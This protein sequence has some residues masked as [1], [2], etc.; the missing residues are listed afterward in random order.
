M[1]E[2]KGESLQGK[3]FIVQGY[4]NVGYWA[5]HFLAKDGAKLLSVQDA[6]ATLFN[7]KGISTESLF[8]HSKPRKGSIAGFEEAVEI[9]PSEFFGLECDILILAALGNQITG[10]NAHKV[11]AS[12]VAEGANG[13]ITSAGEDVLLANNICIIPDILCNSGGV[14]GSYF[15]WLQNRNGELWQLEDVMPKLE[16]KLSEVFKKVADKV[17]EKDVDWRTAAY[18]LAV[19]RIE[20]AYVQR[21]I[22]P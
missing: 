5:S 8:E 2:S 3:T 16:K 13:P 17:K 12:L 6:H 10:E 15:E 4:G 1:L 11:K 21:G 9:D 7:K 14:I 22:F 20:M 19:S 18:I